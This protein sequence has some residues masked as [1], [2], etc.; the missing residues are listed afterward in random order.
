M[1]TGIV[2][3]I[4]ALAFNDRKKMMAT[5]MAKANPIHKLSVTLFTESFTKSACT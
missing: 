4:V 1:V 3:K 2:I 5:T